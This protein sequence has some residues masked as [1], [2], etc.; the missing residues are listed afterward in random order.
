MSKGT[1]VITG[2]S[3]GLGAEMARQ[4]AAL[5]YD[6]GL[7]ARR[8]EKLEAL[9]EEITAAHPERRVELRSLD[10]T[11]HETVHTVIHDLAGAF[12]TLDRIVV[13]AGLGKGAAL[14]KGRPDANRQTAMTNFVGALS[15]AE[16]ALEVFRAQEHGHL[17][18]VSSMSALRGMRKAMTV[19]AATKAGVAS[20]AEGLRS[21]RVPGLDVSVVYP[22]YIRSE[23]NEHVAQNTPF[24]VDTETGTRAMVRAIEKRKA[25]A[26]VP[27]WPWVPIGF[28][29]KR[30]PLSVVRRMT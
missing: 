9:R 1:I 28:L 4:F 14:G 19:Y 29:L 11:D 10:V 17:V 8:E 22:G 16:A 24:M 27:A 18:M 15:Q 25:K 5:G 23:M 30:V 13:N 2:A 21:E 12:G 3:A 26:Y 7:C 6:L 20:L